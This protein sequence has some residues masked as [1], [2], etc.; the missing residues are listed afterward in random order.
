[1]SPSP[2]SSYPPST[3]LNATTRRPGSSS[4]SS[5]PREAAP[6]TRGSQSHQHHRSA[7]SNANTLVNSDGHAT[8]PVH[9]STHDS[10]PRASGVLPP[11][12]SS[13]TY[14]L[15]TNGPA[16]AV[17]AEGVV[18]A[19]RATHRSKISSFSMASTAV[20]SHGASQ[21]PPSAYPLGAAHRST[22]SG[23]SLTSTVNKPP[24]QIGPQPRPPSSHKSRTGWHPHP[25]PSVPPPQPRAER[26]EA[27]TPT[28]CGV[29]Q[30]SVERAREDRYGPQAAAAA[31][32]QPWVVL[33]MAVAITFG[34]MG[35]AAYVYIGV[36]VVPMLQEKSA[37]EGSRREGIG[38]LIGFAIVW[39]WM[40]WSY[41]KV[42]LTSPG[43]AKDYVP[44]TP[45]P[46]CI[47][48]PPGPSSISGH[49]PQA[50]QTLSFPPASYRRR[51][52]QDSRYTLNFSE[53]AAARGIGG[54]SYEELS[55]MLAQGPA[56]G[57]REGF[58]TD[59]RQ[60]G[61]SL[62]LIRS[63]PAVP[64]E[65][66]HSQPRLSSYF[67]ST[68]SHPHPY[69]YPSAISNNLAV[70]QRPNVVAR[71]TST[72]TV[73]SEGSRSGKSKDGNGSDALR[74]FDQ[75]EMVNG[76]GNVNR[77]TELSDSESEE[78][79]VGNRV[80]AN[81]RERER[82][83]RASLSLKEAMAMGATP[84]TGA[85]ADVEAQAGG[86]DSAVAGMSA[87]GAR[88][89]LKRGRRK[90]PPSGSSPL[91]CC[92]WLAEKDP[93]GETQSKIQRPGSSGKGKG[94]KPRTYI[95]RRPPMTP[96]LDP[97]IRYCDRDGFVKPHRAH[98]C[99]SCGTCVLKYDHHCP[100]IG[101]CVGA[102]NHKFF[103]NF[104]QAAFVCCAYIVGSVIPYTVKG[105]NEPGVDVN[106]QQIVVVALSALFALFTFTLTVSHVVMIMMGQTTVENMQIQTMR[107]R[108]SEQ[109][110][111]AYR[112]L[113]PVVL[114]TLVVDLGLYARH[115]TFYILSKRSPPLRQ[116][117]LCRNRSS[118][119]FEPGPCTS[120]SGQDQSSSIPR[121]ATSLDGQHQS[122]TIP[123]RSK[124]DFLYLK[125]GIN[126]RT[127]LEAA[128]ASSSPRN[129]VSR[130]ARKWNFRTSSS[131]LGP[132]KVPLEPPFPRRSKVEFPDL[133]LVAPFKLVSGH[134]SLINTDPRTLENRLFE[135]PASAQTAGR[136][137]KQSK[138]SRQRFPDL[139]K[140]IFRPS[141]Q[142]CVMAQNPAR[143]RR[144]HRNIQC[145]QRRVPVAIQD[146][147][148]NTACLAV[149]RPHSTA[150]KTRFGCE[151]T[152]SA[153]L[154]PEDWR[155]HTSP[156]SRYGR[157]QGL[158]Q[159]KHATRRNRAH[160]GTYGFGD[161]RRL[162]V[163]NVLSGQN[164]KPSDRGVVNSTDDD[165]DLSVIYYMDID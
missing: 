53:P 61:R 22:K 137:L 26:E 144:P 125:L 116:D 118:A 75:G 25:P 135:S 42:I 47:S 57:Q 152:T 142:I 98:H 131:A 79:G 111:K 138:T 162:N 20:D 4:S 100:W 86:V 82:E 36:L 49:S 50:S 17:V 163:L 63:T 91:L 15:G 114:R 160:S 147:T 32:P 71:T 150:A 40:L 88:Q 80:R 120:L 5:G 139:Q 108:E 115:P 158:F 60:T 68:S 48:V 124:I 149:A 153:G 83:S 18:G 24:S 30:E 59:S 121:R 143:Y 23:S 148:P 14:T 140:S 165:T 58:G 134:Q 87:A 78:E 164:L 133:K 76:N 106:P 65:R 102:R 19:S 51:P 45:K 64:L 7:S 35:Y 97:F 10:A 145:R 37:A 122:T 55:L 159:G 21:P 92:W 94:A 34:L 161:R 130:D 43:Y 127:L 154:P 56:E 38:L 95:S 8:V 74:N 27:P 70:P 2:S 123:G 117:F 99:R 29:V 89:R 66:S 9:A 28:C 3:S 157:S 112:W 104:C 84:R 54:P 151:L 141:R 128:E 62:D 39:T 103:L 126:G 93:F 155:K 109:L 12:P 85:G 67:P 69:P 107:E 13:Y 96:V 46:A 73:Q 41:V 132:P 119:Q 129:A 77:A 1:M 31:K 52:S 16:A 6:H 156:A 72:R 11:P 81:P 44:K 90:R 136:F 110:G 105:F 146:V 33:K 113:K 101:Q